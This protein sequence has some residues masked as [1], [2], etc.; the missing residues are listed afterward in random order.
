[1]LLAIEDTLLQSMID[2]LIGVG[3]GYDMEINV[4]KN[5]DNENFKATNHHYRL[6]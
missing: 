3:R 5:E 2:K 6:K 1:V 4:E